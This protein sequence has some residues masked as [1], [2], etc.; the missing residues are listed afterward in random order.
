MPIPLAKGRMENMR[1]KAKD[2]QNL[3]EKKDGTALITAEKWAKPSQKRRMEQS[4][5]KLKSWQNHL[6]KN[7]TVITKA[8][9]VATPS[10]KRKW[11]SHHKN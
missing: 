5:Q 8:T 4:S 1:Q 3:S 6:R 7:G 2:S 11:N 10:H 9:N